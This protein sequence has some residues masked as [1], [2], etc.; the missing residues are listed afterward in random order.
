MTND[1]K[2]II[3]KGYRQGTLL[4]LV[5]TSKLSTGINMPAAANQ[6]MDNLKAQMRFCE[7]KNQGLS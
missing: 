5:A 3:E 4:V 6:K 2:C 7:A 1:K